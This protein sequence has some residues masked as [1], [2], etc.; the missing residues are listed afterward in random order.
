MVICP[1]GHSGH[2][3]GRDKRSW[4]VAEARTQE[5]PGRFTQNQVR[6]NR[7]GMKMCIFMAI[8]LWGHNEHAYGHDKA[9][10]ILQTPQLSNHW[11]GSIQIKL[12]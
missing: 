2:A 12:I 6:W 8:C 4:N 10:G 11:A 7:L 5:L 9:P 3:R 1:V